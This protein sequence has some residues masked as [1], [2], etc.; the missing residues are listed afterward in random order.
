MAQIKTTVIKMEF[1]ETD[2]KK[3]VSLDLYGHIFK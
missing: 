1:G 3:Q 2:K